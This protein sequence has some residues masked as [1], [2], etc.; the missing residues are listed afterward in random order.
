MHAVAR[1]NLQLA[2]HKTKERVHRCQEYERK[3]HPFAK[4]GRE[5]AR[6]SYGAQDKGKPEARELP[7]LKPPRYTVCLMTCAYRIER[8]RNRHSR[9]VLE[10]ETIVIRLARNLPHREEQRHIETLLRRMTTMLAQQRKKQLLSAFRPDALQRQRIAGLVEQINAETLRV[11]IRNVRLR[12]M[13]TQWGSCSSRGDITLNTALLL[14]P[15]EL[16]R[17]VI[18]HELA[19]CRVRNHS[20]KFWDLVESVCPWMDQARR[21]LRQYRTI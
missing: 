7:S 11:P 4:G 12:S 3:M 14:L 20:K 17:Y 19:H 13:R 18:I 15:E 21:E 1:A 16:L 2:F 10:Q 8:T 5:T 9:A 6:Y